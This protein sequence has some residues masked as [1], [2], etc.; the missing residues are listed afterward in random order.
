MESRITHTDIAFMR[1]RMA[2]T[3]GRRL[4]AMLDARALQFGIIRGRLRREFPDMSERDLNLM[5]LEEVEHAK[6]REART[7]PV[8]GHSS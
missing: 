6:R 4:Q 7:N 1:L 2:L 8:P 3:P 5:A